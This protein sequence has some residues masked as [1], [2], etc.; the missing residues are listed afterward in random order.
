MYSASKDADFAGYGKIKDNLPNVKYFS[1]CLTWNID[2][3]IGKAF[4]RQER[5]TLSEKVI[6][7]ILKDKYKKEIDYLYVKYVLEKE[8]V[9]KDLGFSNK[10]GKSRIGDI[11]I[12][13]PINLKRGGFDLRKQKELAANYK[14]IEDIKEQ[15]SEELK[16]FDKSVIEL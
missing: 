3:Y 16:T 2:G 10:A 6:P 5:F 15:I 8:A 12:R 9:K 11:T 14:K 1:N 7:L 13:I 4:F